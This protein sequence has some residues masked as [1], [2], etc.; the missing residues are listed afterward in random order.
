M[1]VD[2]NPVKEKSTQTQHADILTNAGKP[3]A[4]NIEPCTMQTSYILL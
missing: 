1:L 2:I 3:P 4:K